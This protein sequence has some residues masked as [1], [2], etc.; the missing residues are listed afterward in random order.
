M[1]KL[2]CVDCRLIAKI[3][4]SRD[5]RADPDD[6]QSEQPC[7][8]LFSVYGLRGRAAGPTPRTFRKLQA[9]L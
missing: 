6:P 8:T 9:N 2:G 3:G 1:G 5:D 7:L 4:G